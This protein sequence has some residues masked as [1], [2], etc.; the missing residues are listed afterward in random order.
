M[1]S[2]LI[3]GA[4]GHGKV[5]ADT[6]QEIGRWSKI[7]FLDDKYPKITSVIKCPVLGTLDQI[8][9]FLAQ[10][11]DVHV[12]IGNNQKRVELIRK[13]LQM[14]FACPS[15]VHPRAFVSAHSTLDDGCMV[16]A[17][18][19]VNAG[20]KIGIGCVVNTGSSVG[21][22]C[23]L[24]NG[25]HVAPGARLGGN[26][27]VGDYCWVGI[28]SSVVQ[29]KTIGDNVFVAAGAA[30]HKD[31]KSNVM[32]SGVPAKVKKEWDHESDQ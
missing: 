26:V 27:T 14:G 28:G 10:F 1:S 2:I 17:Q 21:H 18:A 19:A 32:V 5:V 12:A 6:V 23:Y 25:V 13:Y 16:I 20:S 31:I 4:G 3:I 7:A 22:D 30:V 9:S 11:S 15:I 8:S 24:G 29:G